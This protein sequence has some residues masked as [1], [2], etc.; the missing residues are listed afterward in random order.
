MAVLTLPTVYHGFVYTREESVRRFNIYHSGLI[1]LMTFMAGAYLANTM[2]VLWIFVEATT[3]A[4]AV[5]IY[6][7]RTEIALEA[8]WKYVFICS[9]VL[10]C[11]S[12]IL[13]LGFIYGRVMPQPSFSTFGQLIAMLIRCI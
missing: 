4:V 10:P 8:T 1:A 7:D 5:L 3:L 9:T 11:I 12:R 6:H 2:T 13:F